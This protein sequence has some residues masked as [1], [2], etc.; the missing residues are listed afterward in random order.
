MP[1]VECCVARRVEELLLRTRIRWPERNCGSQVS[2][3]TRG[4]SS[5]RQSC[6]IADRLFKETWPA[7]ERARRLYPV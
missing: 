1:Q 2:R 4:G 5:P 7:L 6:M 3:E